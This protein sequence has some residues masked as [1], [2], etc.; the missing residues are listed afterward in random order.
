MIRIWRGG[1]ARGRLLP[2]EFSLVRSITPVQIRDVLGRAEADGYSYRGSRAW[3]TQNELSIAH[4]FVVVLDKERAERPRTLPCF[5]LFLS[6]RNHCG[7][8]RVTISESDYSHLAEC[9]AEEVQT[10]AINLAA[11]GP[12]LKDHTISMAL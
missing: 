4:A 1:A 3:L 8:M 7:H 11:R 9:T 6:N 5:I 10:I 2:S 12:L